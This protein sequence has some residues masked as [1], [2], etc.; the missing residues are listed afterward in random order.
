MNAS[1]RISVGAAPLAE[2][3]EGRN[4]VSVMPERTENRIVRERGKILP[5]CPTHR[6]FEKNEADVGVDELLAG[7]RTA[8]D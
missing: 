1:W 2:L 5:R 8:R 6:F 4:I 7:R 3:G